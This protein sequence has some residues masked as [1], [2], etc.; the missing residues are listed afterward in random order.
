MQ[1]KSSF[2]GR[3]ANPRVKALHDGHSTGGRRLRVA[4]HFRVKRSSTAWP[5]QSREANAVLSHRVSFFTAQDDTAGGK[6]GAIDPCDFATDL[7]EAWHHCILFGV[8]EHGFTWR[9][10]AENFELSHSG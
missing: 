8:N 7:H 4:I 2:S 1:M 3:K 9:D 10:A 6:C 5:V